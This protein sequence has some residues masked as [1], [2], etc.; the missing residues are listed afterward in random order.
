MIPPSVYV[1]LDAKFSFVVYLGMHHYS[2]WEI[3]MRGKTVIG[4]L[5]IGV[6]SN[7]E[8]LSH[9]SHENIY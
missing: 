3:P 7:V 5:A 8:F 6:N 9:F 2:L 4:N 1:K